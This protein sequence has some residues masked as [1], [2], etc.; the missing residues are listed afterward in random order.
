MK[1]KV[2]VTHTQLVSKYE[3]NCANNMFAI[4]LPLHQISNKMWKN[5][6]VFVILVL[7][8]RA[9]PR[10]SRL[11]VTTKMVVDRIPVIYTSPSNHEAVYFS[12]SLI[13]ARAWRKENK[14]K[15]L[16]R[17]RGRPESEEKNNKQQIARAC[18][19]EVGFMN[20]HE[21]QQ[22]ENKFVLTL[23]LYDIANSS[24][25]IS[26]FFFFYFCSAGWA[27]EH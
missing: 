4:L 10:T 7:L 1:L 14:K 13:L 25:L 15:S 18:V 6:F 9:H 26:C 12:N 5:L 2:K 22:I 8:L 21:R 20:D 17:R 23:N 11:C 19:N 24:I 16:I 27:R 3:S